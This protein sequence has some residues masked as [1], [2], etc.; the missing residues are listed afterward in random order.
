MSFHDFDDLKPK[1]N[2]DKRKSNDAISVIIRFMGYLSWAFTIIALLIIDVARP[3]T[4]NF[5]DRFLKNEIR[6]VWDMALIQATLYLVVFEG[7][8]SI[9]GIVLNTTRLKR[10]YDRFNIS[11]MISLLFSLVTI[12]TILIKFNIF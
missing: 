4:P 1:E 3:E 9:I 10:K 5:I 12:A 11:L 6:V 2:K 7:I 8:F